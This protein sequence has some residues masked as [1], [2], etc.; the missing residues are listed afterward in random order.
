MSKGI[1]VVLEGIHAP[2]P[3]SQAASVPTSRVPGGS[4]NRLDWGVL[5]ELRARAANGP[6]QEIGEV[7]VAGSL[8][9]GEAILREKE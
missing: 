2:F 4:G 5:I 7:A 3:S 9:G 6:Q 1:T 8:G